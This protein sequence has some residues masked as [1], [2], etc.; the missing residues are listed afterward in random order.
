[1]PATDAAI[2]T[3]PQVSSRAG[4]GPRWVRP[5][6]GALLAATAVLYVWGLSASGWANAFYSAA[7][8]AGATSWKAMFFGSSDA[9]NFITVDNLGSRGR[10]NTGLLKRC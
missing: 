6:V 7:V 4:D 9:S 3:V 8:Q 5:A 1:M 2:P 10:C